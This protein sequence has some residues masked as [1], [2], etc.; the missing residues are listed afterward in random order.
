MDAEIVVFAPARSAPGPRIDE[1]G[2]SP[3]IAR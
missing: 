3:G 2:Q 1:G